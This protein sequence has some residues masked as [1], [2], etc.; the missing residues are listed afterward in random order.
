LSQLATGTESSS[1]S[2]DEEAHSIFNGSR[3]TSKNN[4]ENELELSYK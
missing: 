4:Q 2:E 3:T 1:K